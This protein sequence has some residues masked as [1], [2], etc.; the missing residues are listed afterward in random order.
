MRTL[1]L[2]I[3]VALPTVA[4]VFMFVLTITYHRFR[5][6]VPELR[7]PEDLRRLRSLAKLQMYLS[8]LGHPL[9]T[10]GG[11]IVTWVVGW[12]VVKELRGL[13]CCYT[14]CCRLSLLL[15]SRLSANLRC[16]W[17]SVFPRATLRWRRRGIA[18]WTCGSTACSPTGSRLQSYRPFGGVD[19]H[20]ELESAKPNR[21]AGL[22]MARPH[23]SGT[24]PMCR[25]SR[26]GRQPIIDVDQV[27]AIE[28][29]IRSTEPGRYPLD[30]ISSDAL[31]SGHNSR[32][33]EV[34]VKRRDRTV[35][36]EPDPWPS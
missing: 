2:T 6:I 35:V 36:I 1:L 31:P 28:P 14:G 21:Q 34:G 22:E 11:V 13:I 32:R 23:R 12:L 33:W 18:S 26:N 5:R 29:A 7:T 4:A 25:I 19:N 15:L 27:E 20:V 8:L 30:E 3:M 17:Q 9:L 10:I 16:R 24:R